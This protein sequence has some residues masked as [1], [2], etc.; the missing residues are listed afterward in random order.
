[1]GTLHKARSPCGPALRKPT[2]L[3]GGTSQ[4]SQ[5]PQGPQSPQG[6]QTP[7]G[8][9]SPQGSQPLRACFVRACFVRACFAFPH[10]PLWGHFTRL[11]VPTRPAAP[12]RLAAPAGLLCSGLRC[13][14]LRCAGLLCVP[15]HPLPWRGRGI[16]T[17]S[18][19]VC[20]NDTQ[21]PMKR[22][23]WGHVAEGDSVPP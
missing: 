9:Q 12:T 22:G 11:A 6:S 21:T 7:Q 16:H 3:Y 19:E 20:V 1:V 2:P 4:G 15:P 17:D 14:G 18:N 23:V 13:A 5:S 10:T 8:P